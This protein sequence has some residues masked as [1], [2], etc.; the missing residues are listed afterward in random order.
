MIFSDLLENC[1]SVAYIAYVE[2]RTEFNR[3]YLSRILYCSQMNNGS[4]EPY[5]FFIHKGTTNRVSSE[6]ELSNRVVHSIKGD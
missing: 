5:F 3:N 6:A 1:M 2:F 4:I